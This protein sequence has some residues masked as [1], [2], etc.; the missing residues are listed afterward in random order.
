MYNSMFHIQDHAK[1]SDILLAMIGKGWICILNFISWFVSI[2]LNFTALCDAYTVQIQSYIVIPKR[3]RIF[4]L[5]LGIIFGNYCLTVSNEGDDNLW[6]YF[7]Y[8]NY[9]PMY[10]ETD[11]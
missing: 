6:F 2:L 9:P 11:C 3:N 4:C 5:I 7:A 8:L 10:E 1:D